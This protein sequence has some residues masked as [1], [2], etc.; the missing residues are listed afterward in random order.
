VFGN[1]E[2]SSMDKKY[3]FERTEK[4]MQEFWEE[5]GIYRFD[6]ERPGEIWSIDTPPPTVSGS[7][8]IGHVFSYVQ[9][10]MT[11]RYKRMRGFNVFYP[12]GFDDNGL[13][14]ERLVEKEEGVKAGSMPRKRFVE[15]C[16][17]TTAKYIGE[18]R[19]LWQSLGFSVDWSLQYETVEPKA[20]RISQRSFLKLFREGKAYM[21][22]SP[23]LWCTECMTSIAQAELETAEK[24]TSFN[25]IPFE[26]VEGGEKLIVATTRPELLYGCVCL[27]VNPDDERYARY[28]GRNVRVPLYGHEIP[29]LPDRKVAMDKG[30]GIVMC[31]TFGD[32]TDAEWY[33]EHKLPY[34]KTITQDGTI[35]SSVPY[36]GGME[37]QEARKHIIGLLDD[38]GLITR[39]EELTH[40][41][42]VHERC[43][44]E[45][46]IIL[47][48]Q[49]YIDILSNREKYLEAAEQIN[50]YPGYMKDRYRAWVE[51]LKWDWCIS[52][53]RYFGVPIPVWYC[54]RCGKPAAADEPQLPVD[55][56]ESRPGRS[57]TC[58]S[59]DFIPETAVLDTWATSSV[60]PQ[61]N[62]RWGEADDISERLLPM[63]MRTQAH[64]IIRTWAFY[65]IVKSLYHTGRIP[66]KDILICGFVLAK[67]NEKISKSKG[68]S[69]MSPKR[70]AEKYSAD[71][72][73]YWAANSRLGTDTFFS[74]D[75]LDI[76]MRF[77]TKLWNAARF[78]ISQLQD[79]DPSEEPE[80]L[81]V[82]RW[83]RERCKQAMHEAGKLLDQYEVGLARHVIDDFFW[84]D[85]CDDY[86][87]I[88]KERLYRPDMHG[89]TE[90]RSA[91]RAL[92]DS[93]L[94]ILKMYAIYVPHI[95][96]YIYQFFFR[97]HENE[98]SLHL[99]RWGDTEGFD[100]DI[101]E[102]GRQLKEAVSRARRVKSA[103]SLSMKAEIEELDI[104][105]E[106]KYR[107]YFIRSIPDLKACC[108][109]KEIKLSII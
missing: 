89:H 74:L 29:V 86:I 97:Q 11:A 40:T 72:I 70:L 99:T 14:T 28:E 26:T 65:T 2:V 83:I 9:A 62:A 52:R 87:E 78:S 43:G 81:P 85:F 46:E 20:Q 45:T 10:E 7:L 61:I 31:A 58:G 15:M 107:E 103:R 30:T 47:S 55:P 5:N 108:R 53:Q 36:I 42:A 50:W 82:D 109:A 59:T 76:S 98:I 56:A 84:N 48:R 63:S 27:F 39:S 18:F 77:I 88:V 102:F 68:N 49:W 66:W 41:V 37:I 16:L 21:K 33:E 19:E 80:L 3:S 8:H 93:L 95:T 51:N 17:S 24:K 101:L 25:Y 100:D 22:E 23:V 105:T 91:Q 34:R 90:R 69:A 104:R 60:T 96:E 106:A 73:R 32:S 54:S 13:P 94:D 57:C 1:E 35:D 12:F 44:K 79:F 75:D 4:E 64:E 71:A 38:K 67:K 92:Y 6:P